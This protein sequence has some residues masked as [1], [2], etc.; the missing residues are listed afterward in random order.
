MQPKLKNT[1]KSSLGLEGKDI[2][3]IFLLHKIRQQ[4][5]CHHAKY[6]APTSGYLT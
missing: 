1:N 2:L 3:G 6:E 4:H 5:W